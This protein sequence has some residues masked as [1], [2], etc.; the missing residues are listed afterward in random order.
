MKGCFE[1]LGYT[2]DGV[3]NFFVTYQVH[4]LGT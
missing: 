4:R 2:A 1:S 3:V